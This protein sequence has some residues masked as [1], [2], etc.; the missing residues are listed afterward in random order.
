MIQRL[1]ITIGCM[2]ASIAAI[3]FLMSPGERPQNT[4]YRVGV[5]VPLQHQAMDNITAGL[6]MELPDA[7]NGRPVRLDIQ[8]AQGDPHIQRAVLH[9]FAHSG[10]DTVVAIGTA[11]AQ[12]AVRLLVTD[13]VGQ[14]PIPVVALD[15]LLYTSP[16]PRDA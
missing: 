13:R 4:S 2:L 10:T 14:H 16:S 1:A 6:R 9:R 11:A 15:C 7:I 3:F 8:N 5:L 12:T